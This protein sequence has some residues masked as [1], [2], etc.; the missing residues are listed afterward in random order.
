[1]TESVFVK[2]VILI[3]PWREKDLVSEDYEILHFVQNDL[4]KTVIEFV[5]QYRDDIQK[6]LSRVT[7]FDLLHSRHFLDITYS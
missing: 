6:N 2:S 3:P 7:I 4:V 1:M 5:D